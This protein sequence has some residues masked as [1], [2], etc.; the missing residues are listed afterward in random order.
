MQ[1]HEINEL[2]DKLK[3][4]LLRRN[5]EG[6]VAEFGSDEYD[7]IEKPFD[8]GGIKAEHGE[9]TVDLLL[10]IMDYKDLRYTNL[11]ETIPQ[12]FN[13]ELIDVV[14][15]LSQEERTGESEYTVAKHFP[16]RKP[17]HSSCR[18]AC[19]GLCVGSSSA[20]V[21]ITGTIS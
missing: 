19:T 18:G 16:D 10:Q 17:E 11:G 12:A 9:K 13:R 14:D 1:A 3:K 20:G 8:G 21:V 15:K 7:F 2:K 6:S 4:E 5:G